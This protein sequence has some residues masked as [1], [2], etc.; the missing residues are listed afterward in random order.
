MSP[1]VIRQI[2]KK[3]LYVSARIINSSG[4]IC[5]SPNQKENS[6]FVK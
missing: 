3:K 2:K 4:H 6:L 1:K 5:T